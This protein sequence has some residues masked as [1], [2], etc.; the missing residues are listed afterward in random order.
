MMS[1]S[2]EE[3]HAIK[4]CIELIN[5]DSVHNALNRHPTP[6]VKSSGFWLISKCQ[7]F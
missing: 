5:L 1:H 6:K 3:V 7:K 4:Q 2:I